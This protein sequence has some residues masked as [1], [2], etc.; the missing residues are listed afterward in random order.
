MNRE[1]RKNLI[2]SRFKGIRVVSWIFVK[3]EANGLRRSAQHAAQTPRIY[4]ENDSRSAAQI[5]WSQMARFIRIEAAT[6]MS[7]QVI[8]LLPQSPAS[9]R[10]LVNFGPVLSSLFHLFHSQTVQQIP[11][12]HGCRRLVVPHHGVRSSTAPCGELRHRPIHQPV[13]ST[14]ST[15]H[16]SDVDVAVSWISCRADERNSAFAPMAAHV[17]RNGRRTVSRRR[18]FKILARDPR[19]ESAGHRR[20]AGRLSRLGLQC[21]PRATFAA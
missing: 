3:A 19:M 11:G 7:L 1:K 18:R 15:L 8:S 14:Q 20:L 4:L 13:G 21:D 17:R 16:S 2:D 12:A 10:P 5:R 6:T 9:F